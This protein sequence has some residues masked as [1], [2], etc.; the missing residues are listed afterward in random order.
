MK[1]IE[2][3]D[4]KLYTEVRLKVKGKADVTHSMVIDTTSPHTIISERLQKELNLDVSKS[5][6]EITLSSF[7]I[8]PLKVSDFSVYK[9]D[10][11]VDGIIGLD[12]LKSVGAKINLDSMTISSS[13]T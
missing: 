7:S 13:R 6:Q 5:G 11:E 8:G 3:H 12:F 1:S 2:F 9:E 4:G 10:I